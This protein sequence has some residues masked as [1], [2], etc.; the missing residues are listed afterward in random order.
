[1][2][3]LDVHYSPEAAQI[4]A[5]LMFNTGIRREGAGVSG[6]VA[7]FNRPSGASSSA[8]F[9]KIDYVTGLYAIPMAPRYTPT[10]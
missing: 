1:M 10:C 7:V 3:A 8:P 6:F 5:G 9:E 2:D 4:V